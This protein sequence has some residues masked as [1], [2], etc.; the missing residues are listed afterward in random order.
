MEAIREFFSN[1]GDFLTRPTNF[2]FDWLVWW[3]VIAAGLALMLLIIIIVACIAKSKKK[4]TQDNSQGR[5]EFYNEAFW[6]DENDIEDESILESNSTYNE[7]SNLAGENAA[8]N[9]GEELKQDDED[10]QLIEQEVNEFI[11][12]EEENKIDYSALYINEV[13]S[14]AKEEAAIIVQPESIIP[15]SMVEEIEQ[16]SI[17]QE[18]I[19][20]TVNE[21]L[22]EAEQIL[23]EA[24]NTIKDAEEIIKAAESKE[25]K[26]VKKPS[27]AAKKPVAKKTDTIPVSIKPAVSK[28]PAAKKPVE[29][30]E[31]GT[32]EPI[33]TKK[34]TAAKK[35]AVKNTASTTAIKPAAAKTTT[36]KAAAPKAAKTTEL[37]DEGAVTP[38]KGG[39]YT[40]A[41]NSIGKYVFTL[42]ANNGHVLYESDE[43]ASLASARGGIETFKKYI[44]DAEF[45]GQ[46]TDLGDYNYLVKRGNGSYV[47]KPY[48]DEAKARAAFMSLKR[49]HET[50]NVIITQRVK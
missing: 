21:T 5:G 8:I 10:V 42:H 26:A 49:F 2:L 38:A 47:S 18:P 4:K 40:V 1:I 39:K 17:A 16:K 23:I 22:S 36:A 41:K 30:K 13:E 46:L 3:H 11:K 31:E 9:Q 50:N 48:E 6:D 27:A 25:K 20:D 35:P 44:K 15:E 28:K 33:E 29:K 37:K 45:D 24:Q 14:E 34:T 32:I 12:E 7:Q 19:Q 43:Y